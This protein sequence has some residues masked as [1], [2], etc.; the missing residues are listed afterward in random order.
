MIYE[1]HVRGFT[2]HESSGI[3]CPGTFSGIMEKIPYLKD[4]GITAVEPMPIFEFDEMKDS[5]ITGSADLYDPAS[6]GSHASV[7]FLNCHD[8][9]TL[10]DMYSY[11]QKHNEANGW[12]NLDGSD[13]SRSWN[14]G[15]EGDTSDKAVLELRK[16]LARNAVTVLLL[17]RG[18]PMFLAA[19]SRFR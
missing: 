12:C 10:W 7:N 16:K 9:F 8:G 3:S 2:K 17:S 11:S 18:T 4:L 6:R 14:C 1:M 15:A 19:Y 13:D 5:R